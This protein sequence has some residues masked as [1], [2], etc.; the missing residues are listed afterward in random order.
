MVCDSERSMS[1]TMIIIVP[2]LRMRGVVPPLLKKLHLQG[3]SLG[4]GK[5]LPLFLTLNVVVVWMF[6]RKREHGQTN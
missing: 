1:S 4:Q 6:K 3:V 2:G 5:I